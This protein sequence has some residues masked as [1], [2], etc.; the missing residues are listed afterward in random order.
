MTVTFVTTHYPAKMLKRVK[1]E[2]HFVT[3]KREAGIYDIEGLLM[4]VQVIVIKELSEGDNVWLKNLSNELQVPDM[5]AVMDAGAKKP[6]G[7]SISAYMHIIFQSNPKVLEE[8]MRMRED[9]VEKMLRENGYIA[10]WQEENSYEIA[11][12]MIPLG[13]KPEQVAEITKLDVAKVKTLYNTQ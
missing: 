10:K 13:L 8:V 3:K 1:D 5:L 4:P 2:Y 7:L 11:R 6:E 9:K 12:N